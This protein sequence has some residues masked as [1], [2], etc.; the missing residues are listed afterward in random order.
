[1]SDFSIA[2]MRLF[3]QLI[4]I[5]IGYTQIFC[6]LM[7]GENI[8]II[9]KHWYNPFIE[10]IIGMIDYIYRLIYN[11]ISYNK[12]ESAIFLSNTFLT[13]LLENILELPFKEVKKQTK[14]SIK[15]A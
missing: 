8:S 15:T 3:Y 11:N 10:E 6:K 13:L 12:F 5:I 2:Y 4:S 9:I 7:R 1:M 14:K